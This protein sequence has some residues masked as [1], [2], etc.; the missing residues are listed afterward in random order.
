MVQVPL[1]INRHVLKARY[2]IVPS[3][4]EDVFI[5]SAKAGILPL[6]LAQ[7]LA[8]A[9]GLRNLCMCLALSTSSRTH[10]GLR[11]PLQR[12][13]STSGY[14]VS[15]DLTNLNITAEKDPLWRGGTQ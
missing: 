13:R 7:K 8:E 11:P 9:S 15:G 5:Q 2:Q 12:R 14:K 4:N 10:P 3:T 1:D 6:E